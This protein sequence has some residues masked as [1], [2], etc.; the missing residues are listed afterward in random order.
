MKWFKHDSNA[1]R[2]SKLQRVM[3]KYGME[4]YGLYWF[5]LELIAQ[6]VEKYNLTFELEHDAELIAAATQIHYERVQEMMADFVDWG[7]FEDRQGIIFCLKMAARTDEYTQQLIRTR[8]KGRKT[9]ETLP[10]NS[11]VI[12][13][14]RIE[15]NRKKTFGQ[16]NHFDL[17]WETYPRKVKKREARDLW[18]RKKLDG[19]ADLL[20]TDVKTRLQKDD[21]WLNGFVP[22][23]TTY[24]RGERWTDEI[25]KPNFKEENLKSNSQIIRVGTQMGLKARPGE[26]MEDYKTRIRTLRHDH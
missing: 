21:A 15:Q 11:E 5:C 19:K 3:L 25:Q 12:E 9:P 2:D 16:K 23:P 8:D 18:T 13:E 4:G 26:S 22:H 10:I 6:T 7:L 1:N 20:I 14:K 17:F 24:L